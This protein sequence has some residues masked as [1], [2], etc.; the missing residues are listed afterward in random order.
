MTYIPHIKSVYDCIQ[1]D[2]MVINKDENDVL[3]PDNEWQYI[4]SGGNVILQ[5]RDEIEAY[6]G[7]VDYDGDY[8]KYVIKRLADCDEKE[9]SC[10]VDEYVKDTIS[11]DDDMCD[12]IVEWQGMHRIHNIKFYRGNAAIAIS[13]EDTEW[14]GDTLITFS[15]DGL[16][17]DEEVLE[18]WKHFF[19]EH[20]I[21][22]VSRVKWLAVCDRQ[23]FN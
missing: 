18:A 13:N 1:Y 12:C 2:G 6:T 5:G 11:M 20:D 22:P 14:H 23:Y 7:V 16:C 21:D 3:L 8:D 10:L 15:W 9:I 4:D 17:T 19:C